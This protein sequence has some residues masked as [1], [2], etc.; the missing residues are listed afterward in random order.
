MA[1]TCAGTAQ[2]LTSADAPVPRPFSSPGAVVARPAIPSCH[3]QAGAVQPVTAP[4]SLPSSF[5]PLPPPKTIPAQPALLPRSA[6]SGSTGSMPGI[7]PRHTGAPD[8]PPP[9]VT[10]SAPAHLRAASTAKAKAAAAAALTGGVAGGQT[11]STRLRSPALK[12]PQ[13]VCVV[14]P[15][16]HRPSSRNSQPIIAAGAT[17]KSGAGVA[18]P[19]DPSSKGEE[20]VYSKSQ[21]PQSE[22]IPDEGHPPMST[23][24]GEAPTCPDDMY[25]E[26]GSAE[27]QLDSPPGLSAASADVSNGNGQKISGLSKRRKT[28]KPKAQGRQQQ[29]ASSKEQ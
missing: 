14:Q 24:S 16:D 5:P 19:V 8:A 12:P 23:H 10:P 17:A 6:S 21:Q 2:G 3:Q 7:G 15:A 22:S 25:G 13:V 29:A 20:S 11:Q 27:E 1:H 28:R 26:T 18:P 4:P 9:L